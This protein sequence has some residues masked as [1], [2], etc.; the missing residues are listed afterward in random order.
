MSQS[1]QTPLIHNTDQYIKEHQ[2]MIHTQMIEQGY[3]EVPASLSKFLGNARWIHRDE[4]KALKE[5]I[6][7]NI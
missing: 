2:K 5:F 6:L 4:L 7:G 1:I 3:I